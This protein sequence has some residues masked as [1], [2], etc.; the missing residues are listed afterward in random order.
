MS[1]APPAGS[2]P[3][4]AAAGHLVYYP[5]GYWGVICLEETGVRDSDGNLFPYDRVIFIQYTPG[6]HQV[7]LVTNPSAELGLGFPVSGYAPE[8]NI[9]PGPAPS[10]A[11]RYLVK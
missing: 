10:S 2:D 8:A 6:S 7:K 3:D 5:H 11:Y 1:S 4:D 9:L